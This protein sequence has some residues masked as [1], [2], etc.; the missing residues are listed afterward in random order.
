[1]K[2]LQD[3]RTI[4]RNIATS[5]GYRGDSV[6]LL[7]QLLANASYIEEVENISYME[8]SS[9][10]KAHLV[11]SKIQHCMD[12]MYSVYR[13]SCPRVYIKFKANKIK[14]LTRYSEIATSS[15]FNV[16]YLGVWQ[17][18]KIDLDLKDDNGE[19]LNNEWK[20][21]GF[22][23]GIDYSD[24][25]L[26]PN[27]TYIIEC[28]ISKSEIKKTIQLSTLD[29]S[30]FINIDEKDLSNDV[31]VSVEKHGSNGDV[32]NY[33][34][35]SD[36][37]KYLLEAKNKMSEYISGEDEYETE[38]YD[39][40][41][42]GRYIYD[43]TTTDYGSR[44]YFRDSNGI[45]MSDILN[46]TYF[47]YTRLSDFLTNELSKIAI[48]FGE[49][50]EFRG[51]YRNSAEIEIESKG[52]IIIKESEREGLQSIHYNANKSR[53]QNTIVR[54]NNDFGDLLRIKYPEV[55]KEA[56]CIF[57][58]SETTTIYYIPN[59]GRRLSTYEKIEFVDNNFAYYITK[60]INIQPAGK[61]E[62]VL[63]VSVSLS[64]IVPNL[65]ESIKEAVSKYE[66]SFDGAKMIREETDTVINKLRSDISKISGVGYVKSLEFYDPDGVIDNSDNE[67]LIYFS[68]SCVIDSSME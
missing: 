13:G 15:N 6:D 9:L 38:E 32:K 25:S 2:S 58:S 67:E 19:Y 40:D 43:L 11:N 21:D 35:T 29:N 57:P 39:S 64:S 3:Y 66:N 33:K 28:F 46:A 51:D 31:F 14:T 68:I 49:Y 26:V 63:N 50:V 47:P 17:G 20:G 12:L 59:E 44:L 42:L 22:S 48:S 52:L 18:G 16:Y 34:V 62:I 41:S 10:E 54:S 27:K 36:F 8:E 7:V 60:D 30:Y 65:E 53:Y 55:V 37:R 56:A 1:M 45:E 23:E 4:Y 61:K 24:L 5:L